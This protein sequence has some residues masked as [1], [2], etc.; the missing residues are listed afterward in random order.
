[1]NWVCLYLKA[2]KKLSYFSEILD[3]SLSLTV[4]EDQILYHESIE[5]IKNYYLLVLFFF[6]ITSRKRK[7]YR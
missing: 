1:M 2:Q 4:S 3:L 6:P 7:S 5:N